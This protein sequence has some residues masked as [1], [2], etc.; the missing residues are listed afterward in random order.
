M[1]FEQKST[2]YDDLKNIFKLEYKLDSNDDISVIKIILKEV[3]KDFNFRT[4]TKT[5]EGKKVLDSNVTDVLISKLE[6]G[7]FIEKIKNDVMTFEKVKSEE[8]FDSLHNELCEKFLDCLKGLYTNISYGKAQKIVNMFFKHLYCHYGDRYDYYFEYCHMPLD[9]IILEWFYRIVRNGNERYK[10]SKI[11]SW[12]NLKYET[13]DSYYG[14]KFF[15][16]K[17]REYFSRTNSSITPFKA[18]FYIWKEF[19]FELSLEELFSQPYCEEGMREILGNQNDSY[20]TIVKE[21]KNYSL[22]DKVK[23]I[24]EFF[25]KN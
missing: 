24:K 20:K 10:K 7:G 9:S 16:E 19:Q 12:S 6:K 15:V 18:E 2:K 3:F 8:L 1:N 25:S 4:L 13:N 14:Y 11:D 17:I 5:A 22:T 23:I 21:F